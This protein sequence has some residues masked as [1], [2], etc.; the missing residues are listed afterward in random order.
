MAKRSPKKPDFET[1]LA[2]LEALVEKMEQGDLSL[3]ESL[4][5]FERGIQL[6]RCCQ[7]ALKDAEQKVQILLKKDGQETLEPFD[8]DVESS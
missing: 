7:Q 2:E 4:Q 1:A 5:Q 8:S 3:D 6:T